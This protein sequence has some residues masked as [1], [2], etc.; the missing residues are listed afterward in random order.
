MG[1]IS[2]EFGTQKI[3]ILKLYENVLLYA[4]VC[5]FIYFIA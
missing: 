3:V 2:H 4:I 1:N 5:Y